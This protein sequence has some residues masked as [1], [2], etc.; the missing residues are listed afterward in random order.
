[1]APLARFPTSVRKPLIRR[2][3]PSA[4]GRFIAPLKLPAT[5]LAARAIDASGAADFV[6]ALSSARGPL[7]LSVA[8]SP[9]GNRM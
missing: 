3:K 8:I 6:G 2:D 5:H 7:A 1:M 4:F 9:R